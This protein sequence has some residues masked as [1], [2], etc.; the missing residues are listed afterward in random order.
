MKLAST[1]RIAAFGWTLPLLAALTAP[2]FAQFAPPPALPP[3][4]ITPSVSTPAPTPTPFP[5]FPAAPPKSWVEPHPEIPYLT[6]P[7]LVAPDYI[8]EHSPVTPD[9]SPEARALLHFLYS[10]SGKHTLTGQHNYANEQEYSTDQ[11]AHTTGKTPVIYGTDMGFAVAGDKDSAY[12][13][14]QE[15][16]E[17]IK[18]WHA[19]HII[20]ICWHE[21]P[22][23]MDE[24]VSFRTDISG[25]IT[26]QQYA[27]LLTPGTAVYRHWCAQVDVIAEYLQELQDAHVPVLLRPYHEINGD[28]FWWNGHRG[29]AT[30]GSKQ[31]YR[32][33][34]DRLVNFHH[35]NN[36]LFVWNCDQPSRADRQFIDYFPGQGYVD[37]FGLDCYGAFQ[38][39]FY[40]DMNALSDGKVMALSEVGNPPTIDIYKTQPKWTYYMRWAMDKPRPNAPVRPIPPALLA[41]F[42]RRG[43]TPAQIR[44]IVDD[45]RMLSMEDPAY[46][47]AINPVRANLGLAPIGWA[48]T[49]PHSSQR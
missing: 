32:Q 23:T 20:A 34:W 6:K 45:P 15:V 37:I 30:H 33:M 44:A 42:R 5:G 39:S 43:L 24:P 13:R 36:L 1:I 28:W 17:L 31:L 35:L 47:L 9:A 21:V 25:H 10:I 48:A 3:S 29:D 12:V 41:Q 26:D 40:D 38:Q 22:P 27:D 49:T 11:V 19:G 7:A 2:A 46:W 4:V 8:V 14:H 16:Q 18:Q